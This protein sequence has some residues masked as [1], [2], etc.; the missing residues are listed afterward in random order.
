MS[1]VVIV[2]RKRD[3]TDTFAVRCLYKSS[4]KIC[5]Y[6]AEGS[7]EYALM[8]GTLHTHEKERHPLEKRITWGTIS[9]KSKRRIHFSQEVMK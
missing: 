9:G 1:R 2:A 5:D 3:T 7:Y 4:D 8:A 6:R